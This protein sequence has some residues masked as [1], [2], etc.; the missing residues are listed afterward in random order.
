MMKAVLI[1]TVLAFGCIA[2]AAPAEAGTC[3][4]DLTNPLKGS[5]D[6][7]CVAVPS[8]TGTVERLASSANH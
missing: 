6:T 8:T 4:W 2:V 1:A 5:I 3:S 7:G